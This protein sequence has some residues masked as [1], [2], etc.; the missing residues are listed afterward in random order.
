MEKKTII[1]GSYLHKKKEMPQHFN[2]QKT[3]TYKLMKK[4]LFKT[5]YK[6]TKKYSDSQLKYRGGSVKNTQTLN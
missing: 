1:F 5:Y 3:M 4:K 6:L 2:L